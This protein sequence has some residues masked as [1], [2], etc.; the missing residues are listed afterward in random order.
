M[1]YCINGA[2]NKTQCDTLKGRTLKMNEFRGV[3]SNISK[4]DEYK[5]EMDRMYCSCKKCMSRKGDQCLFKDEIEEC[6]GEVN[7]GPLRNGEG[8]RREIFTCLCCGKNLFTYQLA[9]R[10]VLRQVCDGL[11]K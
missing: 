7:D 6:Y 1:R 3:D 9:L 2:G 8:A 10:H 4:N 11:K 5:I